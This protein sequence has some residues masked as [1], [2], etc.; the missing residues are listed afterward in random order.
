MISGSRPGFALTKKDARG[1][2]T[3]GEGHAGGGTRGGGARKGGAQYCAG[4]R[5]QL[6]Y[7]PLHYQQHTLNVSLEG[8]AFL[9]SFKLSWAHATTVATFLRP[10]NVG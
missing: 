3:Q 1:R 9:Y 7:V 2:G 5:H 10:K 8:M 6:C 4:T